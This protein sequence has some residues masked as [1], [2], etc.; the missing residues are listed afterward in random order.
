MHITN[1]IVLYTAVLTVP[2]YSFM[3]AVTMYMYEEASKLGL[4]IIVISQLCYGGY[5]ISLDS[6][7]LKEAIAVSI[8]QQEV[9]GE[10]GSQAKEF[11]QYK[12]YICNEEPC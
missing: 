6:L 2:V 3:S 7:G 5:S 10:R 1:T 8:V 12:S 9:I 4:I 11:Q